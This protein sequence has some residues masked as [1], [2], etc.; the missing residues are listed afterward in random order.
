MSR[1]HGSESRIYVGNLPPDV[2]TRD[3]E[4]LFYKFGKITYIDLKNRRGPPFSFIEFDDPRFV[5]FFHTLVSLMTSSLATEM[6][7]TQCILV[8]GMIM[9]G[10]VCEWSFRG[11]ESADPAAHLSAHQALGLDVSANQVVPDLDA[12]SIVL[13]SVVR[14]KRWIWWP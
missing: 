14:M 7:K 13:W 1:N 4:D 2:R 5:T 12:R 6:R 10:I 9:T 8:T 3:I 11:A